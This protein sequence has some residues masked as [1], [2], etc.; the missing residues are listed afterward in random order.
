MELLLDL[1]LSKEMLRSSKSIVFSLT[2]CVLCFKNKHGTSV[3]IFLFQ[4]LTSQT[5]FELFNYLSL[6]IALS[7]KQYITV[8]CFKSSDNNYPIPFGME[9]RGLTFSCLKT[10]NLGKNIENGFR[11]KDYQ[12]SATFII[13]NIPVNSEIAGAA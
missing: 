13:S 3:S 8:K 6:S 12:D 4:L 11:L 2:I 5:Q 7:W 9:L 10:L 1:Q